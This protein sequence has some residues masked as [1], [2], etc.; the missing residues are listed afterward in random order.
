MNQAG[1]EAEMAL[2]LEACRR[3]WSVF[4]PYGHQT[5]VDM[6]LLKPGGEPITVQVKKGCKQRKSKP[7]HANSWKVLIGSCKSSLSRSPGPRLKRYCKTDFDILAVY[8]AELNLFAFYE[9]AKV[10]GR[11]SM[12][13]NESRSRRDNWELLN[14]QQPQKQ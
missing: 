12:R 9:L 7:H 11:S 6:I 5:K 4:T 2:A 1:D 10:Y 13:W 8:V 3:G 14:Q